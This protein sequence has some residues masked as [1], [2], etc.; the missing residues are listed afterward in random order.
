M[1]CGDR[2]QGAQ[3][4]VEHSAVGQARIG[5]IQTNGREF[6]SQPVGWPDRQ[7]RVLRIA[8][9]ALLP[10]ATS[11][12]WPATA[13]PAAIAE[14]KTGIVITLDGTEALRVNTDAISVSPTLIAVGSDELY[15]RNGVVRNFLGKTE[16]IQRGIW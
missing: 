15:L 12:L 1:S 4:L 16:T 2:R 9:G 14:Q 8:A 3:L 7:R 5:W 6:W 13:S 10:P 11:S